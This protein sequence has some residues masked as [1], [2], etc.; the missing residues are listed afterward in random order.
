MSEGHSLRW[1]LLGAMALVFALG[2]LA[3]LMSYRHEVRSHG[4]DLRN[5]TLQEQVR[6]LLVALHVDVDGLPHAGLAPD[7]QQAY[8]DPSGAFAYTLFDRSGRSVA[9]SAN[10]PMP[11]PD[12]TVSEGRAFSPIALVGVG[13][14]ERAVIAE[15]A[16]AG[17]VLVVARRQAD[18]NRLIDSLFQ[19]D[20]EQLFVLVPFAILALGLIWAVSLWSL[21]PVTRASREAASVGRTNPELRTSAAGLPREICS[22]VDA[23]NGA[24]DRLADAYATERRVTAERRMRCAHRSRFSAFGCSVRA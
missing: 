11:L 10:L 4:N 8:A 24:L 16:P 5:R 1:R 7:W 13:A 12:L 2:V 23:V 6:E 22:L 14:A 15:R 17:D 18:F 9:R 21:R 19:E 3:S 20:S